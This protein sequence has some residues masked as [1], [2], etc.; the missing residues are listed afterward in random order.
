MKQLRREFYKQFFDGYARY[1]NGKRYC[2]RPED[3]DGREQIMAKIANYFKR[4]SDYWSRRLFVNND[5]Y[6]VTCPVSNKTVNDNN[7]CYNN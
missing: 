6:R 2:R 7:K 3:Y 5:R 4:L 1:A